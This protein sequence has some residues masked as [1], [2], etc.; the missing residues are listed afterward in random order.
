[1]HLIRR[2]ILG[3]DSLWYCIIKRTFITYRFIQHTKPAPAGFVCCKYISHHV[4]APSYN[5]LDI[6][7][8]YLIEQSEGYKNSEADLCDQFLKCLVKFFK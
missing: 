7:P 3:Q 6:S 1:M 8:I 5:T 4:S 2:W